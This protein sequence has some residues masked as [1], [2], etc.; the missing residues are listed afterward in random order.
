MSNYA[1]GVVLDSTV[2]Q[3]NISLEALVT[4]TVKLNMHLDHTFYSCKNCN[5]FNKI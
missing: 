5:H 2:M 1:L 4:N 3:L